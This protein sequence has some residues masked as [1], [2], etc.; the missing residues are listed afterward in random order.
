MLGTEKRHMGEIPYA[1]L[2]F[3]YEV[4]ILTNKQN[5]LLILMDAIDCKDQNIAIL[6]KYKDKNVNT[7]E[8]EPIENVSNII[9]DINDNYDDNLVNENKTIISLVSFT[10]DEETAIFYE[11]IL[12]GLEANVLGDD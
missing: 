6:C 3:F 8:I 10:D 2:L 4:I 12:D 11:D 1:I 5:A 7:I 9:K